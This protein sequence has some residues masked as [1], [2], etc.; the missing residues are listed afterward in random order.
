[1]GRAVGWGRVIIIRHDPLITNGKVVY[2]RYA[3]IEAPRVALGQR[4]VRGE[5]IASVGN[6]DGAYPYHLHFDV[7]PTA[8]LESQPGQWPGLNLNNL[9]TNY[10]DPKLFI[11]SIA[12]RRDAD[13]IAQREH[14]RVL[15]YEK[16]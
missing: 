4:V 15:P 10:V 6:A 1:V 2:A 8:I 13:N 12:L 7:S 16:L 11:S 5:Q 3:H 9:L 14:S